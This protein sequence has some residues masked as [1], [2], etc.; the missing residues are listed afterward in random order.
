MYTVGLIDES[1]CSCTYPMSSIQTHMEGVCHHPSWK[2]CRRERLR[3]TPCS[4][5]DTLAQ[6]DGN[7]FLEENRAR[8][9]FRLVFRQ[10][11]MYYE[12][13]VS[14]L[15]TKFF[16]DSNLALQFPKGKNN[17]DIVDCH[18]L[19]MNNSCLEASTHARFGSGHQDYCISDKSPS[20]SQNS[21]LVHKTLPPNKPRDEVIK[22]QSVL[23]DLP[24]TVKFSAHTTS[25]SGMTFW[26][27][28][29]CSSMVKVTLAAVR[30][31]ASLPTMNF[32]LPPVEKNVHFELNIISILF[33][34]DNCL[35]LLKPFCP[36][37]YSW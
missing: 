3:Y 37:R 33:H 31:G 12:Y 32:T 36:Q 9:G 22:T 16:A 7:V 28:G 19:L 20:Y 15:K 26:L 5:Q 25:P 27:C 1:A 13:V 2:V 23:E 18:A 8:V 34:R 10:R 21:N 30:V 17:T 35:T 4:G 24:L 11:S 14:N 6:T 29:N